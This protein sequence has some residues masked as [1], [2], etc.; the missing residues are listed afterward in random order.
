MAVVCLG[1]LKMMA[2]SPLRVS[3]CER[4]RARERDGEREKER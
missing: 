3:E 4:E 2:H 1:H